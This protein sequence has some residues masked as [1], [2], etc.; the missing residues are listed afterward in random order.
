MNKPLV[1]EDF[2]P[3]DKK[4][5]VKAMEAW[6][7]IL[8]KRIEAKR[9]DSVIK[10]L[11]DSYLQLADIAMSGEAFLNMAK[12]RSG[13]KLIEWHSFVEEIKE[14]AHQLEQLMGE[15]L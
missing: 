1:I 7:A 10:M 12:A 9:F 14:Q 2:E 13:H 8:N 4:S 3:F 6:I 15:I 5:D 11:P